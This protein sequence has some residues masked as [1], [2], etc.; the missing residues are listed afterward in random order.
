VGHVFAVTKVRVAVYQ[1]RPW[2]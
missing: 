1:L 2:V